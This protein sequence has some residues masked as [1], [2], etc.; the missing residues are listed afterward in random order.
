[1]PGIS[2]EAHALAAI[3]AWIVVWWIG[4]PVPIPVSALLGAV[5]CILAGVADARTVLAPF[6]EPTIFLFLGSFILARAMS[7]HGLDRSFAFGIMS[8]GWIGDRVLAHPFR[9]RRH[10]GLHLHVDQQHRHH[11]HD[12]PHRPAASSRP[13]PGCWRKNAAGRSTRPAF[14]SPRA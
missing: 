6:A 12:V 7:V 2:P 8:M 5:L 9:L 11:G 13:W 10:L 4:E 14:A 3:I 1:M